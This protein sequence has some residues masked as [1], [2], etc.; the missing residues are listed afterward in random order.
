MAMKFKHWLMR[1]KESRLL[2][3][4]SKWKILSVMA[5]FQTLRSRKKFISN[6]MS[7]K[8]EQFRGP[9]QTL[10]LSL[11]KDNSRQ[12]NSSRTRLGPLQGIFWKTNSPP[13]QKLFPRKKMQ[14][15]SKN[16]FPKSLH[17]IKSKLRCKPNALSKLSHNPMTSP[18]KESK[19][20]IQDS[21]VLGLIIFNIKIN[22]STN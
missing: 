12:S 13:S 20:S 6:K 16:P 10:I 11:L 4:A 21:R 2:R 1:C 14:I 17:T 5:P 15:Y 8:V 3:A 22:R 19:H 18:T 7:T 9:F